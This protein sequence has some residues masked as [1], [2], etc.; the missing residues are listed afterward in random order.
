VDWKL[1]IGAAGNIWEPDGTSAVG[2]LPAQRALVVPRSRNNYEA[3]KFGTVNWQDDT[4]EEEG[5]PVAFDCNPDLNGD[6][7]VDILDFLLFMDSF[8]EC[9]GDPA[10]CGLYGVN[11]DYLP[12]GLVDILDFLQFIDDF[13]YGC[14]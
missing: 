6:G 7:D 1:V 11:A 2:G 12:D 14:D 9:Q 4:Y 3:R 10:P 5:A 13:S 8:S